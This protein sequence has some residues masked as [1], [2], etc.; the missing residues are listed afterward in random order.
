MH[1]EE[2]HAMLDQLLALFGT[3]KC[4]GTTTSNPVARKSLAKSSSILYCV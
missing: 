4:H 3:V 2:K 1:R